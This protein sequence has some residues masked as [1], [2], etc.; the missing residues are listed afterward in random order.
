MKRKYFYFLLAG[1]LLSLLSCAEEEKYLL[2][3]GPDERLQ[4]QLTGYQEALCG[5]PCGWL[6]SAGTQDRGVAGGAYR[7]WVKFTPDNR[8]VM[9]GD[10]DMTTATTAKESSYRLKAMQYPTLMFDTY[11]Y[12]H[13]LADATPA[14][15]GATRGSG[16]TSDFDVNLSGSL[17]GNEFTA[18][19]RLHDCPFIFTKATPEDTVAITGSAALATIKTDVIA[20]W[21]PLKYPTV[22]IDGFKI[23]LSIGN[24]L[25]ALTYQDRNNTIQ[26]QIIPSYAEFNSDIRLMEPFQYGDIQ[27]DRIAWNGSQH[28]IHINGKDCAVYDNGEPF[29]A[30]EF[31]VGKAYSKI[32]VDKSILNTG[33]GNS[34][35]D[36]FLTFYNTIDAGLL[37]TPNYSNRFPLEYFTVKFNEAT[38][39][40]GRKMV[41]SV[42]CK[43]VAYIPTYTYKL[44]ED[45]E[46]NVYFTDLTPIEGASNLYVVIFGR[47]M[48]NNLLSYFLY[49]GTSSIILDSGTVVA[50]IQPS[51]NKFKIDWAPNNTPGLSEAIGGFYLV[52]DPS[53]Y[54]PGILGN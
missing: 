41:L 13:M 48:V 51:G 37:A 25:S 22:N 6:V 23:Q 1:T 21:T 16:L 53:N 12:I 2:G 18:T 44:N 4:A 33:G 26:A 42:K 10:I 15:A 14:L 38:D 49:S 9:Y 36:P 8:V 3:E 39:V 32:T 17:Q 19:G 28:Q 29:Y 31:G 54:M 47:G 45:A 5:A 27:F 40:S 43:D 52:S 50:T 24:R 46:G 34:M 35:V 20:K 7:F 30:L 11:N